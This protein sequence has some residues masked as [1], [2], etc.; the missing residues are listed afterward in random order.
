M[1]CPLEHT[2][3]RWVDTVKTPT[4]WKSKHTA[5]G[6]EEPHC[7]EGCFAAKATIQGIR[8]FLAR[9]LVRRGQ[10]TRRFFLNAEVREREQLCVQPLEG[11]TRKLL[12]DGRRVHARLANMSETLARTFVWQVKRTWLLFQTSAIRVCL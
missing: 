3:G 5:R 9:C 7:D 6:Y 4:V 8:M 11:W 12:H 10:G 2:S 1:I